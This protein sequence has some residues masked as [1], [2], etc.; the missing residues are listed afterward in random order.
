ME[1]RDL[2]ESMTGGLNNDGLAEAIDIT[3][4]ELADIS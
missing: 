2:T 4:A 1:D 3:E